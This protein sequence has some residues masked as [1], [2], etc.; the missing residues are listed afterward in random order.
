MTLRELTATLDALGV[1]TTVTGGRLSFRARKG[2][3]TDQLKQAIKSHNAALLAHLELISSVPDA[4][5]IDAECLTDQTFSR[6][7][8]LEQGP[9]AAERSG[10]FYWSESGRFSVRTDW[11]EGVA[12]STR[13][14]EIWLDA[15]EETILL[16]GND[17]PLLDAALAGDRIIYTAADFGALRDV[18][19]GH[20]MRIHEVKRMFGG[21]VTN[22]DGDL[23]S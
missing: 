4:P 3:L 12:H 19:P 7:S 14:I 11:L 8:I 13:V 1:Q 15:L 2:V 18:T 6:Q 17:A 20:L 22:P 21:A 9:P 10:P 16:V 5:G 23:G